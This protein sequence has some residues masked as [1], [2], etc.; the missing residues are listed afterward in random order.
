MT[1]LILASE[2]RSVESDGTKYASESILFRCI[3]DLLKLQRLMQRKN[4]DLQFTFCIIYVC[5]PGKN[6]ELLHI[7]RKKFKRRKKLWGQKASRRND[8]EM[9]KNYYTIIEKKFKRKK[10]LKVQKASHQ[11]DVDIWPWTTTQP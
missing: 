9:T 4:N 3:N 1:M 5:T 2:F 8:V 6:N 10:E 11:N 7:H